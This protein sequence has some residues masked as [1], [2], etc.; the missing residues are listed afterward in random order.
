VSVYSNSLRTVKLADLAAGETRRIEAL[1]S[2]TGIAFYMTYHITVEGISFPY[3]DG[4]SFAAARLDEGKT[5]R[6]PVPGVTGGTVDRVYVKLINN[7]DFSLTFR[8]GNSELTPDGASSTIVMSGENAVYKIEAGPIDGYAFKKNGSNPVAF[9]DAVTEFAAGHIYTFTFNGAAAALTKDTALTLEAIIAAAAPP[10]PPPPAAPGEFSYERNSEG[11]ITI[12]KYTG[13]AAVLVIP[14]E[15][16]GLPVTVID[17]D[18]F[19]GCTSLT[20]VTI[21]ASVTSIGWRAFPGCMSLTN[22]AIDRANTAYTSIDG[23]VFTKDQTTL[24]AYPGGKQGAYT[25]PASVTEIGDGAFAGCT[26]LRRVT[27]SRR[28]EVG[29]DAFPEGARIAYNG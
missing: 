15:I 1:P 3:Y 18:A 6:V 2:N 9:P 17:I 14:D 11:G 5:A 13:S 23:V 19:Y 10:P 27:L 22:I 20:S 16:E 25:I 24:A 21:P 26:S 7:G 29:D 4:N 12:K 28:T 8:K